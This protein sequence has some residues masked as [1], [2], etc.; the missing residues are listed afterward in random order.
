MKVSLLFFACLLS[1]ISVYGQSTQNVYNPQ[2]Y[3]NLDV[4]Q[5]KG[6]ISQGALAQKPL[7]E[8]TILKLLDNAQQKVETDDPIFTFIESTRNLLTNRQI[9]HSKDFNIDLLQKVSFAQ[10]LTNQR[11]GLVEENGLGGVDAIFQPLLT[12]Q[13]GR[14]FRNSYNAYLETNQAINYKDLLSIQ[15]QPQLVMNKNNAVN[16]QL[17]FQKLLLNANLGYLQLSIGR[18]NIQWGPRHKGGLLLSQNAPALDM[19]KLSVAGQKKLPWFLKKLGTYNFSTFVANMG[20]DYAQSNAKMAAYRFD[21]Q[22]T[23]KW[24]FAVEH[25]VVLGGK[26]IG[27]PGLSR[28]IGEYV[29]FLI[30]AGD[31]APSNHNFTGSITRN[32]G[33]ANV[34]IAGMFEDIDSNFEMLMVHNATWLLGFYLPEIGYNAAWSLR[35]ELIRS[36]PRAYRHGIY[37]DGHSINGRI[38]GFGLGSDV[39]L[40]NTELTYLSDKVGFLTMSIQYINRSGDTYNII[41][42]TENDFVDLEINENR[43]EENHYLL[44]LNWT[45]GLNDKLNVN[46]SL[47]LDYT[48]NYHFV[49]K[50]SQLDYMCGLK[51]EFFPN[52]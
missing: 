5:A 35:T 46:F 11:E 16:N 49:K 32:F 3:A 40:L 8:Q 1:L 12:N 24:N 29:G 9:N 15:L 13:E 25:T 6:L 51:V 4:L 30:E 22:P 14:L 28:A 2:V 44:G 50:D 52:L 39:F 20:N 23:E 34:Y 41:T 10:V 31:P 47:G 19:I 21:F 27:T 37:Q 26:G 33:D 18:D 36:A 42:E 38:L 7:K 48:H 45:K 43:P 17:R